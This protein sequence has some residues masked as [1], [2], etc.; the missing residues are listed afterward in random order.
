ML[1]GVKIF[2]EP[3]YRGAGKAPSELQEQITLFNEIRRRWPEIGEIAIH[4]RNEGKKSV[5]AVLRE[6]AEGMVT[7]AADIIIPGCPTFVCELK[8]RDK[9]ARVSK[10]QKTYLETAAKH[11]A[12][13]CV[14]YGY[15]SALEAIALW[16]ATRTTCHG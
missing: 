4:V 1:S 14:C 5:Q 10:K 16:N 12:F 9:G 11:G 15:E 13:S 3:K 6:K 7:G 2:G 8:R